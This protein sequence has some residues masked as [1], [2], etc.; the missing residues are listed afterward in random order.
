MKTRRTFTREFK[1]S[2]LRELNNKSAAEVCRE[3]NIHQVLVNTWK[4]EYEQNPD[5]AFS[6]HGNLWKEDAKI[7]RYERLIGQLYSEIT[8]LKKTQ[9]MMQKRSAEEKKRRSE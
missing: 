5:A 6:G 7:A 4:R 8:L 9:E 2:V 1:L 3:Y